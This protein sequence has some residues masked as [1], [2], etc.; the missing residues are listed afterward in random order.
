ML[1]FRNQ[2]SHLRTQYVIVAPDEDREKVMMKAQPEQFDDI[3]PL[4]FPYSQVEDLYSFV[5]RHGGRLN[6]VKKEDF[7]LNFKQSCRAA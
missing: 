3:R 1:S 7:L 6:G 5:N 4:F 2:A